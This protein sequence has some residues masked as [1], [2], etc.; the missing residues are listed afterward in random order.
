MKKRE[1][2]MDMGVYTYVVSTFRKQFMH[3]IEV[4]KDID[5]DI[6]ST[7]AIIVQLFRVFFSL[8]DSHYFTFLPKA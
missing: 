4:N 7:V 8:R 2:E 1:N 3:A 6:Y 5:I